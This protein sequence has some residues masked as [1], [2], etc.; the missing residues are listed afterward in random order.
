METSN[1]KDKENNL[2]DIEICNK[3]MKRLEEN[4]KQKFI[5][6]TFA[7]RYGMGDFENCTATCSPKEDENIIFSVMY[8]M[9]NEK[10][11]EDDF[12][13]KSTSYELGKYILKE[14]QNKGKEA[15][16]KVKIFGKR[17]LEKRYS[18]QEFSEKYG[19]KNFLATII[20]KDKISEEELENI[21][22]KINNNFKNLFL[23]TLIY[24]INKEEFNDCYEKSL[25]L[26]DINSTFIEDYKVNNDYIIK[27]Y[28]NKI[29]KI[30]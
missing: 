20:I 12:F 6:K 25:N 17:I 8:D 30:K 2:S 23:K 10:I 28:E 16:V 29:I 27:I 11:V 4:Y 18:V 1:S 24:T 14:L 3:I 26:P 15:I 19:N 5:I 21:F 22:I 7:K 13:L 9:I